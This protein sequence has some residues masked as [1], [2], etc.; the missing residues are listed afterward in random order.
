[1][2]PIWLWP[3]SSDASHWYESAKTVLINNANNDFERNTGL[4]S[5]AK[6]VILF[7][8][9]GMGITTVTA[10]R[11]MKGQ[12]MGLNGEEHSLSFDRFPNIALSKVISYQ[13]KHAQFLCFY[14]MLT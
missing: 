3:L 4:I 14:L 10:A 9:D 13:T 8:G 6:N 1:M 2:T 7:I 5:A 11:I 12:Q